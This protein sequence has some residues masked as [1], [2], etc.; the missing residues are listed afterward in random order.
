MSQVS[1]LLT[2][3]CSELIGDADSAELDEVN[4]QLLAR[5]MLADDDGGQ[6]A[7]QLD[8]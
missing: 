6:V 8:S 4:S 5:A 7:Y 3:M 2:C 1:P